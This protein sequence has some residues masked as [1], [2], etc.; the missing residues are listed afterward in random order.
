MS[1]Y[2]DGQHI[3]GSPF[4]VHVGGLDGDPSKV[5]AHGQGLKEGVASK[6][7]E[8]TVNVLDAGSGALDFSI[9][10]PAEV[11][12]NCIEQDDQTYKVIYI[13]TVC[14]MYE[15]NI[16]FAGQHISNSPF[17]VTIVESEDEID[18]VLVDA[19]KCSSDSS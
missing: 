13:P 10:G 12:L 2:L 14:G 11:K 9:T 18:A 6:P 16:Q 8:F 19:S 3:P 7:A 17:K 4:T 5:T 1:V 15:V